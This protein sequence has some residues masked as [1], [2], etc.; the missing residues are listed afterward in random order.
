M[1]RAD[2]FRGLLIYGAGDAAA[3]LLTGAFGWTRL[4]GMA[5]IGATLYALEIPAWFRWIDRHEPPGA[6]AAAW[7]RT[8]WA[9]LYFN[10]LWIARHLF[11]IRLF[12]GQSEALSWTLLS[13]G[14]KSFLLNIPIALAAN[15]LI[16]NRIPPARRFTASAI[17]SGL[18]AVYYAW[19]G[20]WWL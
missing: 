2:L 20:S 10:P 13:A 19:S 6:P 4:A 3:A 16:Q 1:R 17:F 8:G 18:M 11:F 7:R 15:G 9:L 14:T 5:G 12:A